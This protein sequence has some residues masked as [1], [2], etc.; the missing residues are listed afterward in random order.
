MRTRVRS[1]T[2]KCVVF[3]QE[4]AGKKPIWDF[5]CGP[6]QTTQYLRKLGIEISGLDLSEKLIEQANRIHPGITFRK[7]NMLDLEF[8]NE[9][10]AERD[11]YPEV[12]FQSRRAYAFAKK[13][14]VNIGL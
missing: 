5:G 13:P 3:S 8:K 12:E 9:S 2:C 7:G 10:I 1:F 11:P 6:G 14:T 4:V